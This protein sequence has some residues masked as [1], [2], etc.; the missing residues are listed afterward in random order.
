M[1]A[2]AQDLREFS[3]DETLAEAVK[4]DFRNSSLDAGHKALCEWA[5][6]LTLTPARCTRADVESLRAAGWNDEEIVS[7]AQIIGF[8]N[9]LNRLADGLGIDLEPEMR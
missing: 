3:K 6:K 1:L 4:Q 5:E 2:H 9:H 8:F 7:A